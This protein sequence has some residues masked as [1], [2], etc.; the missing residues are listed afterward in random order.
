M[1]ASHE[2]HPPPP[3]FGVAGEVSQIKI[4]LSRLQTEVNWVR[5]RESN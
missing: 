2:L 3:R 4:G 5:I 1:P